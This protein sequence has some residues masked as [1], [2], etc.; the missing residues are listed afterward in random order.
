MEETWVWSLAGE[1]PLEEGMASHSSI[2]ARRTPWTEELGGLQSMRS[3]TVRHNWSDLARMHTFLPVSLCSK[4]V[5]Y[6]L[7][8]QH[9]IV[10]YLGLHC[11]LQ[12]SLITHNWIQLVVLTIDK[13]NLG[14]YSHVVSLHRTLFPLMFVGLVYISLVRKEFED[15]KL[16]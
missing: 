7:W 4:D 5:Y 3:Q 8:T 15:R 10:T 13:G 12:S 2:L 9:V 14:G 16:S 11:I 1:D 6:M